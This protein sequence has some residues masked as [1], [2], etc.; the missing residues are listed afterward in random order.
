[1]D[2]RGCMNGIKRPFDSKRGTSPVGLA[3]LV[4]AFGNLLNIM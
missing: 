3:L 2:L 4:G 1:M